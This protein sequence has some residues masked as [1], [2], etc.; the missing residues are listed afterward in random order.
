MSNIAI[1]I[2]NLGK[3]YKLYNRPIDKVLDTLGLNFFKKNHYQEFWALRDVNLE[4]KKG[5]RIGII[6]RNGAGKSTLLKTI[7]GNITP[8]EGNIV[9]NG[10]IQALMELGTG[11]HPEFTGRQ[12]IRAS[13]SYQGLSSKEIQL[14]EEEI[15]EFAELE[16]FIDQPIKTYSAG[17]YA[18]LAF[19][20]ATSIEPD[21]LII[22][23]VLGA[24]DAYF[25]SKCIERMKKL[26]NNSG[27]TVLFVSH[28]MSSVEMLCER[29]VWI[30]RGKIKLDGPTLDLSKLYAQEVRERT[31]KRIKSINAKTNFN[32]TQSKI[33]TIVRFVWE[34]GPPVEINEVTLFGEEL[35]PIAIY[36]GEPQDNSME[37]DGFVLIDNTFSKWDKPS[38]EG[39]VQS[40][41]IH[42]SNM[43][44][45]AVVFNL[46]SPLSGKEILKIKWRGK[47]GSRARVEILHNNIYN[48][49][50]V[51]TV[52][53]NDSDNWQEWQ[54][55]LAGVS[56][57]TIT[58]INKTQVNN[59]VADS[60]NNSDIKI[61][62]VEIFNGEIIIERVKFENRLGEEIGVIKSFEDLLVHIDYKVLKGPIKAEFVLC[63]HRLGIIALQALSGLNN[64]AYLLNSGERGRCTLRIPSLPLGK[65]NYFVS[66]G[67]FPPINYQSLDTEK[68]AYILL[69]RKYELIV[70]Q[71]EEIEIDL[72]MCRG[73]LTWSLLK[74]SAQE[75]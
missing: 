69:D 27:T 46:E 31:L 70:E 24:G 50:T 56:T 49:L 3:L 51:L 39:E 12:N 71:P 19:S 64:S 16:E 15:I 66:V 25:S 58:V 60:L 11:F 26:T 63:F 57:E 38:N 52:N 74:K 40:R 62:E 20:T 32:I 48:L 5:E 36:V 72:G 6:G 14:K 73:A 42:G 30:E 65:G 4:I 35:K 45:S 54:G 22:D 53:S 68:T 28:D 29:S 41:A 37:Y 47:T 61:N 43:F 17:M 9:V 23:E 7:I 44:S 55:N 33:Q 67:I 34:Q 1:Q 10:K 13:L 2:R 59:L 8:T 75:V 21:I 18:R